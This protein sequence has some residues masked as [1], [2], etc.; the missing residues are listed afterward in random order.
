MRCSKCEAPLTTASE[1]GVL[2]VG[3]CQA[4]ESKSVRVLEQLKSFVHC[5]ESR[6]EA[7]VPKRRGEVMYVTDT[8]TWYASMTRGGWCDL[9]DI[10]A[11]RPA[12]YQAQR[13]ELKAAVESIEAHYDRCTA[14]GDDT[15]R[16]ACDAIAALA[17][18][19]AEQRGEK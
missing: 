17:R 10:A 19:V 18:I 13:E 3:P 5:P 2:Y 9:H 7:R 14:G 1:D 12:D 16:A 6:K 11:E 4:C 8:H 15:I